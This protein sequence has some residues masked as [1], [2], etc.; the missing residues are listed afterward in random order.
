MPT[1]LQQHNLAPQLF[2]VPSLALQIGQGEIGLLAFGVVCP[3]LGHGVARAAAACCGGR[4]TKDKEKDQGFVVL[5]VSD[6]DAAKVSPFLAERN[7]TY[8][9]LLDPA[10]R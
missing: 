3:Q 8:R 9:V 5:A 4:G 7:I 1:K 2:Q 6:E 10:G